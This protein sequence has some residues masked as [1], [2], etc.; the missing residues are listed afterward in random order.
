MNTTDAAQHLLEAARHWAAIAATRRQ[1]ADESGETLESLGQL[2]AAAE[3]LE[4]SREKINEAIDLWGKAGIDDTD[5]QVRGANALANQIDTAQK[6][7]DNAF[8]TMIVR[9]VESLAADDEVED[10]LEARELAALNHERLATG[11]GLA[12]LTDLIPGGG[13]CGCG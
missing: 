11:K 7:L 1:V 6:D 10:L 13:G 8:C 12:E 5:D 4:R 9:V 2:L 3:S